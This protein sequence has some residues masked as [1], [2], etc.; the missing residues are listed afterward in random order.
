MYTVEK[1]IPIP[2]SA[3]RENA[4][5]KYPF[6]EMEIGDSFWVDT[7]NRNKVRIAAFNEGTRKKKLFKVTKD[8]QGE[9]RCWRLE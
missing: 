6:N 3:K 9:V 4:K 7:E 8:M 2:P 5:R 1:N